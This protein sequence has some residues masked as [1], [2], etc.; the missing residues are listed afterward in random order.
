MRVMVPT[1]SSSQSRWSL[2][3]HSVIGGVLE[4]T[5]Q[6]AGS[7]GVPLS[8]CASRV[9]LGRREKTN[10]GT[11]GSQFDAWQ[12][13]EKGEGESKGGRYGRKKRNEVAPALLSTPASIFQIFRDFSFHSSF[14]PLSLSPTGTQTPMRVRHR[15]RVVGLSSERA[16]PLRVLRPGGQHGGGV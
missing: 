3:C 13:Q 2:Q 4:R 7:R 5:R 6:R 8:G 15:Q 10:G 14:V 9:S 11:Y 16:E 1:S 12:V